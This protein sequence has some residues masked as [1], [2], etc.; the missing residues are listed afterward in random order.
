MIIPAGVPPPIIVYCFWAIIPAARAAIPA[1][2]AGGVIWGVILLLCL[3]IVPMNYLHDQ[4][5]S[6]QAARWQH[7]TAN[8]P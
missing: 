3:S 6:H 4:A 2:I 8:F 1:A 5:K 7:V